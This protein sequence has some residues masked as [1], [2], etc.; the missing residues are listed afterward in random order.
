MLR[1]ALYIVL[2][3]LTVRPIV[4]QAHGFNA[5]FV[6]I[7]K[8]FGGKYRVII[9]YTHVEVG[10]YREAHIDFDNKEE[11]IKSFQD[12][13]RGADFFLGDVKS[14]IHFHTPPEQNKPF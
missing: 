8:T 14:S 11:A 3:S 6:D 1:V 9:K 7:V 10:E 4:V 12:L 13:A 2:I 5:N